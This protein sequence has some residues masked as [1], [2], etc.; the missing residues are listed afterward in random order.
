MFKRIH[1]FCNKKLV[2]ENQ[3]LLGKGS[4]LRNRQG[5]STKESSYISSPTPVYA[6]GMIVEVVV[7]VVVVEVVLVPDN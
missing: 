1:S 4:N 5:G 2:I 7:V 6:E 3:I